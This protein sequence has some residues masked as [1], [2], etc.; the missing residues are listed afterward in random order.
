MGVRDI[1]L[2]LSQTLGTERAAGWLTLPRLM[3]GRQAGRHADR[4]EV[5]LNE[6]PSIMRLITDIAVAHAIRD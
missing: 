6:C 4:V 5:R 1:G 3:L 2:D